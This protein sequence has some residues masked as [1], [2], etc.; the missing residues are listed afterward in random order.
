MTQDIESVIGDQP[1]PHSS[2]AVRITISDYLMSIDPYTVVV[3]DSGSFRLGSEPSRSHWLSNV[4]RGPAT[5]NT[6]SPVSHLRRR[7]RK[8][9]GGDGCLPS[10][11]ASG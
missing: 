7:P 2:T 8:C 9:L 6:P 10:H 1:K 11:R 5:V 3:A 4:G